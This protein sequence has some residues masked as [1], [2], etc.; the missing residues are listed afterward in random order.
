MIEDSIEDEEEADVDDIQDD[1][2]ED[3]TDLDD[4]QDEDHIHDDD[5]SALWCYLTMLSWNMVYNWM[6]NGMNI[7]RESS[8]SRPGEWSYCLRGGSQAD[9]SVSHGPYLEFYSSWGF[10]YP[11]LDLFNFGLFLYFNWI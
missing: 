10:N 9:P 3:D 5:D 11:L 4:I 1:D 7:F 8:F 2:V 6:T